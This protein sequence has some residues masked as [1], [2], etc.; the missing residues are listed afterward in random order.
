MQFEI[1]PSRTFVALLSAVHLLAMMT[2]ALTD[3]PVW[4]R[5]G[6]MLLITASFV[7]Q[8]HLHLRNTQRWHSFTL[9][10]RGVTVTTADG[11]V[12]SGELAETTVVIPHCVVL[13][14]RLKRARFNV[15][16]VI[17][18]DAMQKE[19]FRELRVRLKF[20]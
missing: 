11:A 16:R 2:V 5:A 10:G 14:V 20:A 19:A 7:Y 3:L 18:P 13:C 12:L 6:I 8:C 1:L 17:F 15:R 9:E 4:A